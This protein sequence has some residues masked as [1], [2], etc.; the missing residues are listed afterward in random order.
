GNVPLLEANAVGR[1]LRAGGGEHARRAI[2]PERGARLQLPVEA[3]GQP[4]GA[5][6]EIDDTHQR[7]R[8]DGVPGA[9]ALGAPNHRDEV[10]EGPFALAE[11]LLVLVRIPRV[12]HW[13]IE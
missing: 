10:E 5:A 7:C 12:G 9:T 13:K 8:P 2:D 4:A 11:K 3:M 6:P 1:R